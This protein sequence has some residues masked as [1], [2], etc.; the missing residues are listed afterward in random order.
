MR[1]VFVVPTKDRPRELLALLDNLEG[2]TRV[3]EKVVVV[4]SSEEPATPFLDGK[5]D[6]G[7]ILYRRHAPPSA[8]AQRNAGIQA[9]GGR[10]DLIGLL[11]DDVTLAPDAIERMLAFWQ[12]EES[13][14]V[15]GAAFNQLHETSILAASVLKR[16]RM[17][18]FLGLYARR[19]GSVAPSG[20]HSLIGTVRRNTRVEWLQTGAAVWRSEV[21]GEYE[22]DEYFDSYSYLEDLEFSYTVGREWALVVVADA[23][24]EHHGAPGGRVDA[25]RFGEI[26]VRNRL[27]FV[28]KHGLSMSRCIIGLVIRFGLTLIDVVKERNRDSVLRARGNLAGFLRYFWA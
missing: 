25:E 18:N 12:S 3:P 24:Y 1:I 7:W 17:V 28:R 20:W 16:S 6:N 11:D 19:P 13:R 23:Q 5:S 15:G 14:G 10:F 26:E 27:Y 21:F 8:A 22:F 2:Q 4:D 9:V